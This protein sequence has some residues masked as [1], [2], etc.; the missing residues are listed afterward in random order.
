VHMGGWIIDGSG[1]IPLGCF[2]KHRK[3]ALALHIMR[4]YA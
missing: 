4:H 3:F 2:T 1:D